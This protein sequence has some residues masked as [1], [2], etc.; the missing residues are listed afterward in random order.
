MHRIKNPP[1]A[2]ALMATARSFGNYNLGAALADLIDNSIQ[3]KATKVSV[4][5]V[6]EN[7]GLTVRIR[8]NGTGMS[9]EQLIVAMQ[10]ANVH[11]EDARTATDLGRF[12]WGLKSASFSQA[13][14]LTV[15]TWLAS[16]CNAA[17]WDLDDLEDWSMKVM[18]G[19]A[20]K[21][22]L[23]DA[24]ATATGTEVIWTSCDRLLDKGALATLDELLNEKISL[25]KKHLSLIFHRYMVGE[26]CSKLDIAIQGIVLKPTD[27][28]LTNHSATHTMDEEA[29]QL[30]DGEF[31][32]IKPYII[33]HFSKLSLEEKELLGGDEGLVR[34]QGFYVYRNQRLI[35]HGTWFK[36][37][38]H[39]DVHQ[40]TRVRV[41]LPNSQDID[42]KITLDKSDAQMPTILRAHLKNIIKNFS[43]KSAKAQQR[44][45][46]S[47]HRSSEQPVWKKNIHNGR[48][49]HLINRDHP[50][51][52]QLIKDQSRD[53]F[54]ISSMLSL[55]EAC[56]PVDIMTRESDDSH[57]TVI[58]SLTDPEE[59]NLLIESC[60]FS[61]VKKYFPNHP[62]LNDVLEYVKKM[63]P[64][65][66]QWKYSEDYIRKQIKSKWGLK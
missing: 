54:P 37:I 21:L 26:N 47:L 53:E 42:W 4:R 49:R 34:N 3:A 13:R 2:S 27:P 5:F 28:F 16:S 55:I 10:P 61:C 19:D 9:K 11:P 62:T 17:T 60:F 64:F 58:Q 15:V 32:K 45:G 18:V 65:S 40:L 63:E 25:A 12:G 22:N 30:R 14:V 56:L 29:Y 23:R 24:I 48:I 44:S 57:L 41:D 51:I 59:F 35:I 31:V 7:A 20:A 38:P 6:V 66:S 36:L 50:I 43:K 46:V 52:S 8:D 1:K 39:T 33:P